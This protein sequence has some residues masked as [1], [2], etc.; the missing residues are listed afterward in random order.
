M[1]WLLLLLQLSSRHWRSIHF[2]FLPPATNELD[3]LGG[4]AVHARVFTFL[5]LP[6]PRRE[7]KGGEHEDWVDSGYPKEHA[8]DEY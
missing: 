7:D 1:R 2:P 3:T 6:L 8:D 5:C 4:S